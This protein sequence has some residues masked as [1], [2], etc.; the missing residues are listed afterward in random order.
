VGLG[1]FS[2][3]DASKKVEAIFS[4]VDALNKKREIRDVTNQFVA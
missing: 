1:V 4:L 2:S 3:E